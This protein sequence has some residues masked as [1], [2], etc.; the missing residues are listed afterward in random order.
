MAEGL[1]DIIILQCLTREHALLRGLLICCLTGH[2]QVITGTRSTLY[3]GRHSCHC[4]SY[5][6]GNDVP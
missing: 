1:E 6:N 3:E 4:G 2:F 5:S